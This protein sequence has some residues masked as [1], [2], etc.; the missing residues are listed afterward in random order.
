MTGYSRLLSKGRGF[1]LTENIRG[2]VKTTND[3][4]EKPLLHVPAFVVRHRH[5]GGPSANVRVI[6]HSMGPFAAIFQEAKPRV[7][8]AK[9]SEDLVWL[10]GSRQSLAAEP[11]QIVLLFAASVSTDRA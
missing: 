8:I 11:E 1:L 2:Q 3:C 9:D 5:G 4:F 6:D 7:M 10:L